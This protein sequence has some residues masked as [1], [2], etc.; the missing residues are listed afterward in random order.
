M[1]GGG[2]RVDF[3]NEIPFTGE[4]G[5][6]FDLGGATGG[7][8]NSLL[9]RGAFAGIYGLGDAGEINAVALTP[10]VQRFFKAGPSVIVTLFD[11]YQISVDYM[12]TPVG[13]NAL[14]S[15]DVFVGLAFDT[16]L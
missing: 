4:L 15:H 12:F 6:G 10:T 1:R 14:Q 13:V 9:V 7:V 16:T 5:Y 11:S 8:V 2:S 3:S